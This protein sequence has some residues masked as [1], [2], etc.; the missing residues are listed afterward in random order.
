VL[1]QC[2]KIFVCRHSTVCVALVWHTDICVS[3]TDISA[4]INLHLAEHHNTLVPWPQLISVSEAS[5][6]QLAVTHS[7]LPCQS[8]HRLWLTRYTSV[9]NIHYS[10]TVECCVADWA[11]HIGLVTTHD[12]FQDICQTV[13]RLWTLNFDPSLTLIQFRVLLKTVIF[14]RAYETL[15]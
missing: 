11:H 4:W 5:M 1:D 13:Y 12:C 2:S 9:F 8:W 15:S 7:L 6:S 14:Y 10:C 3:V